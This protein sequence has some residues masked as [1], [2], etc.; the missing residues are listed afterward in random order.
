MPRGAGRIFIGFSFF[1]FTGGG[2]R[3]SGRGGSRRWK[4]SAAQPADLDW[5]AFEVTGGSRAEAVLAPPE[6]VPRVGASPSRASPRAMAAAL[7]TAPLRCAAAGALRCLCRER[8]VGAGKAS[9]DSRRLGLF[10]VY[11]G[12]LNR[13]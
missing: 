2:G 7:R 5:E 1:F 8:G 12:G 6:R 4:R 11:L 13:L 10:L 3:V 9:A